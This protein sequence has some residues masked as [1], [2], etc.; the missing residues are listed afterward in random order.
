MDWKKVAKTLLYPH[1]FVLLLLLP[2]ASAFLVCAMVF[3]GTENPITI[4]SYVLAAYTL[5]IWC[6]RVP[7][8]IRF[9]RTFK[10]ENKFARRWFGDARFRMNITLGASLAYNSLY[11]LFQLWLGIYHHTFW[12]ASLGA[13]YICLAIMRFFL[14]NHTRK[15][16]AGEKMQTEL[17]KY[18]ACGWI[19][20]VMN[21][22]L[23]LVVFFMIYWNRTFE[24]HMITAI[25]MAAYTFTA[26]TFA[27]I[28]VV[29]YR[30]YN[31]PVY[32]ATKAISFASA[33]VS[34][35]TLTSTML[36]TF[37]DG[38]MGTLE[39]K[40]ILG[41]TG[42][43]VLAVVVAMAIRM[44]VKGTKELKEIKEEVENG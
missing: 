38:T 6:C 36:T 21:L 25:A 13:Y 5:T 14:S 15:Y 26:F 42:V 43:A 1:S 41:C 16:D 10:N 23:S 24:H 22:A 30:K 8:I 29:K 35:L 34:M 4:V 27:I 7:H 2:V 12:F 18:R 17:Y 33:C 32:S 19:F 3:L 11:G 39:K 40:W 20:L 31:S 44:I 37:D 9:V 28:N